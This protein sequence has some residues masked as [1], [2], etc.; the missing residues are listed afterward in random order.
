MSIEKF[1]KTSI[2]E[3][4]QGPSAPSPQAESFSD[5]DRAYHSM[6]CAGCSCLCDDISYYFKESRLT[7]TLNL[8]EVGWKRM[9]TVFAEDRVPPPSPSLLADSLKHAAR[10]LQAHPPVLVLGADNADEAAIL[11]SLDLAR[12]FQGISLPWAF[13]G[14]RRFY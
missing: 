10:L 3:E 8:C 13:P 2:Q 12:T 11:A 1:I 5:F 4:E 14:I 9:C 7:R 6:L